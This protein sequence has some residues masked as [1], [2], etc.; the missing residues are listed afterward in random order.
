MASLKLATN[1]PQGI[2]AREMQWRISADQSGLMFCGKNR[3]F[4]QLLSRIF[5]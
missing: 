3:N 2:S 1:L 4:G 5:G